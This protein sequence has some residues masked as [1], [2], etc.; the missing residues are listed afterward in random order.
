[1]LLFL[2]SCSCWYSS[3]TADVLAALLPHTQQRE[4]PAQRSAL[5]ATALTSKHVAASSAAATNAMAPTARSAPLEKFE[6]LAR[7]QK[8]PFAC[9]FWAC[10]FEHQKPKRSAFSRSGEPTQCPSVPHTCYR[11]LSRFNVLGKSQHYH[12]YPLLL[13]RRC[14]EMTRVRLIIHYFKRGEAHARPS[15]LQHPLH[16]EG[17]SSNVL[18]G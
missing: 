15:T 14:P 18:S 16:C 12:D 9:T 10:E 8:R 6:P 11:L 3:C 5:S 7:R 17:L 4:R 1:M 13:S 2:C